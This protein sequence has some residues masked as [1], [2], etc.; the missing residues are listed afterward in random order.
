MADRVAVK[1][2]TLS[3]EEIITR[4]VQFFSTERWRATSQSA[5]AV[6]FEGRLPLPVGM[7]ILTW[8]GFAF[9]VLP[10]LVMYFMILR[11]YYR[12]QNLVVTVGPVEGGSEVSISYPDWSKKVVS[13]FEE[14]LPPLM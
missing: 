6:T 10:G 1:K 11:K 12:F 13:K 4:A 2:T 3:G 14:A 9:C 5:R 8:I 7:L